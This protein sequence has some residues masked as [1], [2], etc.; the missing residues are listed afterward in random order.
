MTVEISVSDA[1]DVDEDDGN[2]G[3]DCG[4]QCEESNDSRHCNVYPSKVSLL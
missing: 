3:E 1:A 4:D 2:E